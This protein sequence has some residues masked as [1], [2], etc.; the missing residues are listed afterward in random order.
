MGIYNRDYFRESRRGSW[1]LDELTPVVKYLIWANIIVYLLQLVVVRQVPMTKHE[2]VA[3]DFDPKVAKILQDKEAEGSAA[4]QEFLEK[5]ER[6]SQIV[7]HV[8]FEMIRN[9]TKALPIVQEW[10]ELDTAKVVYGGQVWRL[11]THAFCHAREDYFHI[12]FNMLFLYWFG[13]T[14]EGRYGR[15]EFLRFY[16]AG[17]LAAASA[18]AAL[19]LYTGSTIPAIGASGAVMA[20]VMLYTLHHPYQT[21]FLCW[22]LPVEMR[23]VLAGYILWDLHPLLLTLGGD[24]V[25]DGIAHAAHLGGALFGFLYWHYQ[26]RLD[27]LLG[28]IGLPSLPRFGRRRRP[29]LR[30][31]SAPPQRE[32]D[33]MSRVDELLQKIFELGQ[34]SLTEEERAILNDASERIRN[35]QRGG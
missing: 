16:L 13:S 3:R 35:R 23:W 7:A 1:G 14:M 30:V 28:R 9:P 22:V 31:V 18:Y 6:F 34:E 8:E 2:V 5:N 20:V 33:E 26:W 25:R 21:I 32:P 12:L 27:G 24:Q 15:R 19:D 11:I 4:Y 29:R 17:A 10:L